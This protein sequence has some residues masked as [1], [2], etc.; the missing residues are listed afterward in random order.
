M[1][2]PILAMA[3]STPYS[4]F[5]TLVLL[6]RKHRKYPNQWTHQII[7][8]GHSFILTHTFLSQPYLVVTVFLLTCW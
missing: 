4:H 3:V 2:F 1:A 8:G 6:V 5:L 7:E